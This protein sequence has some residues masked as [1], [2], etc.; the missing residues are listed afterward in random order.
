MSPAEIQNLFNHLQYEWDQR[1]PPDNHRKARFRNGWEDATVRG[2]EYSSGTLRRLTWH[3]LGYRFGKQLGPRTPKQINEVYQILASSYSGPVGENRTTHQRRDIVALE[4]FNPAIDRYDRRSTGRLFDS[5]WPDATVSRAIA[6]NLAASIRMAHAA[7]DAC[8][9]VTLFPDKIRLNAGQVETLTLQQDIIRFFFRESLEL[10][11]GHEFVIT[12]TGSPIFRAVPVP[13]GI[14]DVAPADVPSLPKAVRE[15]HEAYLQSAASFK[16][17]S[18]FKRSY[19]PGVLDYVESVLGVQLPRPSYV[20]SES[21]GQQVVPLPDEL[22]SIQTLE[23]GARYQV[24][25]NAYERDPRARQL[26]IARH[27]TAC[28]ICGFS[29]GAAYGPMAEGFIHVHHLRPLSEIG[30]AYQINPTE[31]L[32]PVCPNCHAVLHRRKPAYSIEE[33]RAFLAVHRHTVT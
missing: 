24:T 8:W 1:K 12:R 9:G 15:A 31:D 20:T 14:C 4:H 25:V 23:E 22:D 26:C 11:H 17:V 5:L 3:N 32:R 6:A 18:P 30:G 7:A 19:S 10:S 28:V 21:L 29:F 27:G 2:Q 33:V 13:S 16:R